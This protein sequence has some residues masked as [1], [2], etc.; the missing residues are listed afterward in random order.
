MFTYIFLY[1]LTLVDKRKL[2]VRTLY[3]I[4]YDLSLVSIPSQHYFS[5][6]KPDSFIYQH[7]D[8]LFILI[9]LSFLIVLVY[10]TDFPYN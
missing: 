3:K 1:I 9:P 10:E 2:K 5:I 4:I 8:L 7:T 6:I